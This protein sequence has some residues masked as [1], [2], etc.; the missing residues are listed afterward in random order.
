MLK[1]KLIM[2]W[3]FLVITGP[4]LNWSSD[5]RPKTVKTSPKTDIEL[6]FAK[7]NSTLIV[8]E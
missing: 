7:T 2:N 4:S 3:Q 6:V 1:T 5:F 8:L